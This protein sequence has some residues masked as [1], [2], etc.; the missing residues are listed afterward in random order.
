MPV[1]NK[2]ATHTQTN[3]QLSAYKPAAC[4]HGAMA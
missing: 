3:L 4:Y 1:G 2:M